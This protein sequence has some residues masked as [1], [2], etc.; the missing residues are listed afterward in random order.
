MANPAQAVNLSASKKNFFTCL[1]GP[2]VERDGLDGRKVKCI[3]FQNDQNVIWTDTLIIRPCYE[4]L[5]PHIHNSLLADV[6]GGAYSVTGTPGIGKTVFGVFL[7]R[8]FVLDCRKTVLYWH[9]NKLYLFSFDEKVKNYFNLSHELAVIGSDTLYGGTWRETSTDWDLIVSQADELDIMFLHDPV[10]GD[11]RVSDNIDEIPRLLF[12]LSNDH[13]LIRYWNRKGI[14]MK[15]FYM[16]TWTEPE[17]LRCLECLG[18]PTSDKG[19]PEET[20]LDC[21]Y[22]FGGCIRGWVK[23]QLWDELDS[24][25]VE[26]VNKQGVDILGKTTSTRGSI[27][28]LQVEFDEGKRIL[29][30]NSAASPSHDERKHDEEHNM[31]D[32][33]QYIFGSEKVMEVFRERLLDKGEEA[34]RLCLRTWASQSGFECVYGAMFELH[35]HRKLQDSKGDQLRMRIV[36][37]DADQNTDDIFRVALPKPRRTVRYPSNDPSLLGEAHFENVD[38]FNYFWPLSSNH[39]TYDSALVVRPSDLGLDNLDTEEQGVEVLKNVERVG[40]LLQMTVSGATGLPRRPEHSV[41]QH[42][43][44]LFEAAFNVKIPAFKESGM[45]VTAFMVPTECFG[46]FLFQ[47]EE[48]MAGK[49]SVMQPDFQLVFEVPNVFTYK[50]TSLR[51]TSESFGFNKKRKMYHKYD[52]EKS[53]Q[54]I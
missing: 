3:A 30:L 46:P 51:A 45:A 10:E 16:P 29:D 48:T 11:R 34:L 4:H 33:F 23:T 1:F 6:P 27:I 37:K 35:C 9:R 7:L 44:K 52:E 47:P 12:V 5:L 20:S 21:F 43:R 40:L 15:Y 17:G 54:E 42:V 39:P 38:E 53:S 26:V 24:K 25:V 41:K 36:Y 2:I 14:P 31:F 32:S 50:S 49:E 28:H 19:S 18:V 8:H 22:R 13:E